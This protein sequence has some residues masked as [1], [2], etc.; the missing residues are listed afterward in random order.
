MNIFVVLLI[1]SCFSISEA[2]DFNKEKQFTANPN[3]NPQVILLKGIM[4]DSIVEINKAIS[5]GVDID[6]EITGKKPIVIAVENKK[7]NACK[8]LLEAG[9]NTHIYVSGS[10]IGQKIPLITCVLHKSLI[11]ISL[12]F[13]KH[14]DVLLEN[15]LTGFEAVHVLHVIASRPEF[16]KL[17]LQKKALDPNVIVAHAKNWTYTTFTP[18]R[19]AIGASV[20]DIE[21]IKLLVGAGANINQSFYDNKEKITPLQ[22]AIQS[23]NP[24]AVAYL[25]EQGAI[26]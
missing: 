12:L 9:V 15:A 22:W 24:Q 20:R 17:F 6:K 7:I 23:N 13:V 3:Q 5:A 4:N 26:L 1:I 2:N 19:V 25:I 16:I 21:C 11:E 14:D 8:I 18:L 10:D